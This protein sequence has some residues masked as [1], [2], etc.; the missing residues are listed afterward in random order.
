MEKVMKNFSA[1]LLEGTGNQYQDVVGPNGFTFPGTVV[2]LRWDLGAEGLATTVGTDV[3][4]WALV[5]VRQG[6]GPGPIGVGAAAMGQFYEPE[7]HVMASGKLLV[8]T[9]A[10]G[11]RERDEGTTKTMRKMMGGD[12][13]ML[14][15]RNVS[16]IVND[17]VAFTG[18]VQF[19]IKS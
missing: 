18:V 15:A 3:V 13:I 10:S 4:F 7:E 16:A 2:G 5:V 9:Q 8:S 19:F 14:L 11:I 17:P 1:T 6:N 12:R